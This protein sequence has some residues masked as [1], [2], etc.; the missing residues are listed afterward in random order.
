MNLN[1]A[2]FCFAPFLVNFYSFHFYYQHRFFF[3]KNKVMSIALGRNISEEYKPL[4]HK[5]SACLTGQCGLLF[6]NQSREELMKFF[7]HYLRDLKDFARTG[8]VASETVTLYEG[9]LKQFPHNLE[10]YLRTELGMP[11]SLQKGVVTLL[12][13]FQVCQ[14]GQP[15]TSEQARILVCFFILHDLIS[16]LTFINY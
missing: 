1:L 2:G 8:D 9:P 13:D 11:T 16:F 10:P 6:T 4:L 3:G 7:D 15:L 14:R 5:L 12:K